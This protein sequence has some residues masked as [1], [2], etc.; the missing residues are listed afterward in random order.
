MSI[1]HE[2]DALVPGAEH[3]LYVVE[4]PG[5][6]VKVG[7]TVD[8][9]RRIAQHTRDAQ[10]YGRTVERTWISGPH[11][12]AR[13]SERSLVKLAGGRREYLPINFDVAVQEAMSLPM[14]RAD[15]AAVEKHAEDVSSFFKSLLLGGTR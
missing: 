3:H 5:V 11:V 2:D 14:T 10:A 4:I 12:E 1:Q 15:R 7:I 8:P 6:G 13:A 9:P